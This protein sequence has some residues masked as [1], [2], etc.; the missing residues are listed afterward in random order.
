LPAFRHGNQKRTVRNKL[1]VFL[2]AINAEIKFRRYFQEWELNNQPSPLPEDVLALMHSCMELVDLIYWTPKAT[3]GSQGRAI[4]DK[5][6]ALASR[7]PAR[8]ARP[9]PAKMVESSSGEDTEMGNA[10]G[11][12]DADTPSERRR[13]FLNANSE[14]RR[15]MGQC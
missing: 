8:A 5:R 1:N 4:I 7:N 15:L 9:N 11:S 3:E 14:Q 12:V 2:V 13:W 6:F 10:I